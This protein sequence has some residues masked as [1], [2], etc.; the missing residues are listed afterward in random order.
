MNESGKFFIENSQPRKNKC[1]V[2]SLLGVEKRN[3]EKK[4]E[5]RERIWRYSSSR[6]FKREK[7]NLVHQYWCGVRYTKKKVAN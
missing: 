4:Q 1:N 3:E 2:I 5:R 7:K 6:Y